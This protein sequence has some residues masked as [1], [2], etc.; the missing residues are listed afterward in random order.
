[1]NGYASKYKKNMEYS[2]VRKRSVK[3][4]M[5]SM[6]MRIGLV[7]ATQ[8][9]FLISTDLVLGWFEAEALSFFEMSTFS[10]R[11]RITGSYDSLFFSKVSRSFRQAHLPGNIKRNG[12]FTPARINAI[13]NIHLQS[14]TD[15]Y[16]AMIGP[17]SGPTV[18]IRASNITAFPL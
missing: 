12:Q 1:M 3:K 15:V 13:Q 11:M 2:R 16:P 10:N 4:T 18:D 5:G 6:N 17:T 9:S 14:C 7:K 8:M